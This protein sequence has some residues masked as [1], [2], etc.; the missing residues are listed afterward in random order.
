MSLHRLKAGGLLNGAEDNLI[1]HTNFWL[2][3]PAEK[4]V[5]SRQSRSWSS[6]LFSQL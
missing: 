5:N 3:H 4:Q 2:P 6:K 1:E